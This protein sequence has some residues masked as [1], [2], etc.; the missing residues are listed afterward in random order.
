MASWYCWCILLNMQTRQHMCGVPHCASTFSPYCADPLYI[1]S[2][3]AVL[4]LLFGDAV[5]QVSSYLSSLASACRTE[6]FSAA[7]EQHPG[8]PAA[9]PQDAALPPSMAGALP[10]EASLQ[11]AAHT[12]VQ[13][14]G[15]VEAQQ[16]IPG[17]EWLCSQLQVGLMQR[18]VLSMLTCLQSAQLL[19][20]ALS[21]APFNYSQIS[22][23]TC[24]SSKDRESWVLRKLVLDTI[25]IILLH[26]CTHL[27]L[28]DHYCRYVSVCHH[29]EILNMPC[30]GNR[31]LS[32]WP[33][34]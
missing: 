15:T 11:E 34:A 21:I 14:Q 1:F 4:S 5:L 18:S 6:R 13:Q 17:M 8:S 30:V 33:W 32:F 24:I 7:N 26:I 10:A 22:S 16:F 31:P 29:H 28:A 12:A 9:A 23:S 19:H 25:Y 27:S 3:V 2:K 20:R